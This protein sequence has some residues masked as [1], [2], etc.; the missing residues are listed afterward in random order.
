MKMGKS[1]ETFQVRDTALAVFLRAS[2]Q[3]LLINAIG[4][5]GGVTFDGCTKVWTGSVLL[6]NI[7]KQC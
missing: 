4:I 5:A 6:T 3:V 2:K 1:L 7:E